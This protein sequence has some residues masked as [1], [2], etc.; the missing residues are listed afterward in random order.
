MRHVNNLYVANTYE[1]SLVPSSRSN[2][3]HHRIQG[4]ESIHSLILGKAITGIQAFSH[5]PPE[6]TPKVVSGT[7]V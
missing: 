3:A 1:V 2:C 4:T 7:V 5:A 6:E